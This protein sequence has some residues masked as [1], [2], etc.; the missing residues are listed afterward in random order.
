MKYTPISCAFCILNIDI[1][2]NTVDQTLKCLTLTKKS[3]Y[4][5]LGRRKYYHCL[6]LYMFCIALVHH[7]SVLHLCATFKVSLKKI[8]SQASSVNFTN[9]LEHTTIIWG[10]AFWRSHRREEKRRR[11]APSPLAEEDKGEMCD[12]APPPL[13]REDQGWRR[14]LRREGRGCAR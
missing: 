8:R 10:R 1:F 3:R 12:A 14:N 4:P 13:D 5:I 6:S 7:A 11:R 2:I 9:C